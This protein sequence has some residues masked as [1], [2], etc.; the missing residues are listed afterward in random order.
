MRFLFILEM[1]PLSVTCL[2]R[3]SP[4]LCYYFTFLMISFAMQELLSLIRS[5]FC[6]VFI[7]LEGIFKKILLAFP[8]WLS[9]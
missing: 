7:T 1:N 8:S 9:G 3:F 2:Q 4:I 5:Q 6:F